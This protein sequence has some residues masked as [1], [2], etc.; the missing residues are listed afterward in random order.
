MKVQ[1]C[2]YRARAGR[3]NNFKPMEENNL[4]ICLGFVFYPI[5][6]HLKDH[7][8]NELILMLSNAVTLSLVLKE[9]RY[10]ENYILGFRIT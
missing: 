2:S 4:E 10:F 8:L 7:L 6:L 3:N 1:N 5:V 9:E